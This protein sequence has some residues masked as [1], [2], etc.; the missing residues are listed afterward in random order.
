ML[1]HELNFDPFHVHTR[2]WMID[3]IYTSES[4]RRKGVGTTLISHIITHGFDE[5]TALSSNPASVALFGAAG[6]YNHIPETCSNIHEALYAD[7]ITMMRYPSPSKVR[8]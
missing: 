8:R 4:S 1:L 6:F 7:N 3:L 2:P 5:L